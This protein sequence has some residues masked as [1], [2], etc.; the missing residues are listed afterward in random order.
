MSLAEVLGRLKT[1][2]RKGCISQEELDGR[3]EAG[4]KLGKMLGGF[5]RYL[6]ESD[7]K[8]RGRFKPKQTGS[9]TRDT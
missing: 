6:K 1:A 2:R 4:E 3:L 7:F 5:I 9:G 8:D